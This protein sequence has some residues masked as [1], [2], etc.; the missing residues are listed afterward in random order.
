MAIAKY[1]VLKQFE[2]DGQ[3]LKLGQEILLRDSEGE[4]LL[5][6]GCLDLSRY[7]DLDNP[8]DKVIHDD[9]RSKEKVDQEEEKK[10]LSKSEER[11][12]AFQKSE[13]EKKDSSSSSEEEAPA[14][15]TRKTK[16]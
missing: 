12:I 4:A 10:E 7:L 3:L 8:E 6:E 1:K 13:E 2:H 5:Q 9:F 15:K 11:R 14:K 16:K